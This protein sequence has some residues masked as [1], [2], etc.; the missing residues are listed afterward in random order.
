MDNVKTIL[1]R[2]VENAG[3]CV[4]A[5]KHCTSY[6]EGCCTHGCLNERRRPTSPNFS[7]DCFNSEFEYDRETLS[8][9]KSLLE[10]LER[11]E[12][13]VKNLELLLDGKINQ[14]EFVENVN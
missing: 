13:G 8:S 2:I 3:G 1:E 5:C 9:M 4:K 10:C 14:E 7:C 6:K 12:N 11:V